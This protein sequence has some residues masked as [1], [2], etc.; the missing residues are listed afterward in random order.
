MQ[1]WLDREHSLTKSYIIRSGSS[2]REDKGRL[3][4]HNRA[5]DIT[6]SCWQ[7]CGIARREAIMELQVLYVHITR[8]FSAFGGRVNAIR[9]LEGWVI[10]HKGSI[11]KHYLLQCC[12]FVSRQLHGSPMLTKFIIMVNKTPRDRIASPTYSPPHK[13]KFMSLTIEW[14]QLIRSWKRTGKFRKK[15]P[16]PQSL[17]ASL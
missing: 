17:K 16:F 12:W 9:I 15:G 14:L 5:Q 3:H 13:L 6:N 1:E 8:T 4:I 2:Y 10:G 11:S 7:G